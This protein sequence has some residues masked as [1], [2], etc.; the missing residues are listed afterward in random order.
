MSISSRLQRAR[1]E[2]LNDVGRKYH[3]ADKIIGGAVL[4]AN[5]ALLAA[6]EA[7]LH[8]GEQLS[9]GAGAMLDAALRPGGETSGT[10]GSQISRML[11][12]PYTLPVALPLG[13][14]LGVVLEKDHAQEYTQQ[15]SEARRRGNSNMTHNINSFG[16][17]SSVLGKATA[18]FGDPLS[19]L[20]KKLVMKPANM[21]TAT[22]IGELMLRR[23]PNAEEIAKGIKFTQGFTQDVMPHDPKAF[24]ALLNTAKDIYGP[25]V[26]GNLAKGTIHHAPQELDML[27]VLGLAGAGAGMGLGAELMSPTMDTWGYQVQEGLTDRSD[28]TQAGDA[29]M[30]SFATG[31]GGAVAKMMGDM[32]GSAVGSAAGAA[33]RASL[34]FSQDAVFTRAMSMDPLLSQATPSEKDMLARSFSS[35]I[36]FAPNV[37][38]DEFAVKNY[39][40]E[41]MMSSNGPDYSTL[42]NL[43]RVN[44]SLLG[45]T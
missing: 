29:F 42:G 39:L 5:D 22:D 9:S 14:G 26:V 4:E 45:P 32:V 41:A 38:T 19:E 12:S 43:S 27:K 18:A 8:T 15:A 37:A 13:V 31:S 35:M 17:Y 11:T 40:R 3:P 34:T 24:S 2:L 33:G 36:R 6:G 10:W 28:R 16:K 44:Q 1:F 25:G 7:G 30:K 21:D 20:V 23:G